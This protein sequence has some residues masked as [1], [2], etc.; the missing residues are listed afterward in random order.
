MNTGNIK[1]YAP[2][3]RSRFIE[4][5]TRQAARYGISAGHKGEG[6]VAP[7]EVRGD[8]MLISALDGQTHSFPKAL[9]GP[10]EALAKWVTQLGFEQAMEQAAYSWF[11]RLCAIRFMELKGYLEHGR[12]VLSHPDHEGGFQILDDCLE[13]DLAALDKSLDTARVRELKLDGTQDEA[14]YRELLLAQCH[15]LHEAM[16]FLFE[17]LDDASELLLPD[18]LTKTDSLIRE[19]VEAIPEE[20]W[21]DVEVIGWLYQF[22]ITEKKDKVFESL[23]RKKKITAENIPPATQLFTPSWVVKYIIEN[24]LGRLWLKN[25]PKSRLADVMHYYIPNDEYEDF[26]RISSP[27]E[28]RLC[29]PACGSGHMLV[30][31]FDLLFY[32]YEES[33]YRSRDIPRLILENNL[34]GIEIDKRAGELAAFSLSMKAR[35]KSRRFFR[36]RVQ[37]KICIIEDIEIDERELCDYNKFLDEAAIPDRVLSHIK[38]FASAKNFGSLIKIED[39]EEEFPKNLEAVLGKDLSGE[40][41]YLATHNKVVLA[42]EQIDFLRKKYHVLVTNPPY[43]SSNGL[44]KDLSEWAKREYP[45]GRYDLFSMFMERG[46]EFV[47][48]NGF[49]GMITL[50]SWMFLSSYAGLRE[51][52]IKNYKFDSLLH[53]GRG[54][55]GIDWGSCAF[56][57]QKA[58]PKGMTTKFYRLHQRTFQYI[59]K[60]HIGE[61]FV[62]AKSNRNSAYNFDAYDSR[63]FSINDI[64][65][66]SG[67]PANLRNIFY[68]FNIERLMDI[69]GCPF[70]Y[71]ISDEVLEAFKE[72]KSFGDEFETKQGIAT[73]DNENFLRYWYEVSHSYIDL[74]QSSYEDFCSLKKW[75]PYS[76]GG[77]PRRWYGNSELIVNWEGNGENLKSDKGKDG[78]RVATLKNLSYMFREAVTW[79]LTSS[80][81]MVLC[82]RYRP[83]GFV[84]DTNGMSAFPK[85]ADPGRIKYGVGLL[86]SSVS[87]YILPLINP[88]LAYQSGDIAKV[89]VPVFGMEQFCNSTVDDLIRLS[90]LDWDSFETSWD[91]QE[92]ICVN[93]QGKERRVSEDYFDAERF[94][95]QIVEKM[96]N[97]EEDNNKNFIELYA[98]EGKISHA[99]SKEEITIGN[100]PYYRY[101]SKEDLDYKS[102]RRHEFS[103]NMISYAIGCMFGRYSLDKPGLILANQGESVVDYLHKIPLPRFSPDK[104]GII[105]ITGQEWFADDA[106]NRFRDF[107]CTV[108]GESHLQ[109]NLDFIAES[110]CLDTLNYKRSESSLETIRRYLSAKFYKDH[111]SLY[112]KRPIYWLFSSGKQKAFECLI[113]LHRY[114]ESTL[115]EMRTDYVIPL[116]TKIASYVEKLEQDK[117]ASAS[118]AEAKRIEKDL[119]KLYKQQAELNA[120]DEKL[121]HYADQRISLDLDDG[122]KV[123]YGK[124]GDLLAEVKAV[125]G[126]KA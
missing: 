70:A 98:L 103:K 35:E 39:V 110:L 63:S 46:P 88:T 37:P 42:L 20:D 120:F 54:I 73:G 126:E 93:K 61:L 29:D 5:M 45:L 28:I 50:P 8:V 65:S 90:K 17:P 112:N 99:V 30:Y 108:W 13:I 79:S 109:E 91:F 102:I 43:A 14:L 40:I 84:F 87:Q 6:H 51:K 78:K 36:G 83:P 60:N 118:A 121:R 18:N 89:P 100:N 86:N 41:F 1:K 115:A 47:L 49:V 105:P 82:V 111:L 119:S 92:P 85:A 68:E 97:L 75:F 123:N 59:D 9:R 113:Y 101:R 48:D 94:W 106:T 38:G 11:N 62:V 4:T 33:G 125:T 76:K 15:A 81:E 22:Y 10:R 72:S 19:L 44:N 52:L 96:K 3:A 116:T 66:T 56:V 34:Y 77:S 21:Q 95:G 64:R 12:R 58:H 27:E 104:N 124:F 107:V 74:E 26:V 71:W 55:F 69:P 117:E 57:L 53:M 122:V 23:K 80:S 31:A 16:P 32:I 7:A 114:N 24:T 2:K 67:E 25:N